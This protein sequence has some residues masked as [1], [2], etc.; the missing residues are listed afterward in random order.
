V[1][2]VRGDA[3]CRMDCNLQMVVIGMEDDIGLPL[4]VH[5]VGIPERTEL[6]GQWFEGFDI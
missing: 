2:C 5:V 6:C 1:K 3:W 4:L